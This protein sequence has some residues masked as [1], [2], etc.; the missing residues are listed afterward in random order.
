MS[1][2]TPGP[3]SRPTTVTLADVARRA[4]VSPAT[5]SRVINGSTKPIADELRA[6]V[7]RA[8]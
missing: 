7:Q 3:A 5:A 4:R 1:T 2:A 6:R 8:V